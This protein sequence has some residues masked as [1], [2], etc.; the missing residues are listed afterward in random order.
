VALLRI[1]KEF[2]K[3]VRK[4]FYRSA[5][6]DRPRIETGSPKEADDAVGSAFPPLSNMMFSG[7]RLDRRTHV[8]T[9]AEPYENQGLV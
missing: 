8:E 3:S 4:C 2:A 6:V 9:I 1:Y 7:Q 5:R